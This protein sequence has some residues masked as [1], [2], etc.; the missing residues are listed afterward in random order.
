MG[1]D[2]HK[3]WEKKGKKDLEA[4]AKEDPQKLFGGNLGL[5]FCGRLFE[6]RVTD[7]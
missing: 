4:E 5:K 7:F 3:R 2:L 6:K 1:K